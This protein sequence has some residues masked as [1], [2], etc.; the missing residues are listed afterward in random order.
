MALTSSAKALSGYRR[1]LKSSRI[2]F[3]GHDIALSSAQKELRE[4]FL[5]NRHVT[6]PTDLGERTALDVKLIELSFVSS[7]PFLTL[8]YLHSLSH[9]PT[10]LC[11][12]FLLYSETSYR[13]R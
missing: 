1:L 2:V 4:Q 3:K 11:L 7:R 6:D 10:L 12:Q 5:K 9:S 13:N 8:T